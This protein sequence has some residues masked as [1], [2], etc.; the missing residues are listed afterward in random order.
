MHTVQTNKTGAEQTRLVQE[1]KVRHCVVNLFD[2]VSDLFIP[3]NKY[4]A[5]VLQATINPEFQDAAPVFGLSTKRTSTP[6]SKEPTV[7][8]TGNETRR[9]SAV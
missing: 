9:N 7:R 6:N 1:K 2:P 3:L 4:C 5:L 8:N